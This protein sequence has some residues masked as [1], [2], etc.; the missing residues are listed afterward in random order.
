MF[1]TIPK[2]TLRA[3]QAAPKLIINAKSNL[4]VLACIKLT[5]PEGDPFT[6]RLEA[7]DL[8]QY[9][10]RDFKLPEPGV[11][12][13]A[14]IPYRAFSRF[15]PTGDHVHLH[16]THT[17][18]VF[19]DP[20]GCTGRFELHRKLSD[21]P[22][23]PKVATTGPYRELPVSFFTT[24]RECL[25]F[26]STDETR[27]VLNGI[28]TTPTQAVATDGRRLL[29]KQVSGTPITVIWP[30]RCVKSIVAA[31]PTGANLTLDKSQN[32][33]VLTTDDTTGIF[34]LIDGNYPNY[35]Q[36]IPGEWNETLTF[37]DPEKVEKFLSR[38]QPAD[39]GAFIVTMEWHSPHAVLLHHKK[40]NLIAPAAISGW[41]DA[42]AFNPHFMASA[43]KA[44]GPTLRLI[45]PMSP[46]V[47]VGT[48][49]AAVLM[50]MRIVTEEKAP[51]D[52]PA[53]QT[54]TK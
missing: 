33:A 12:G 3:I 40:G 6:L 17:E 25:P 15:L 38:I 18:A 11:Y 4:P 51:A 27:Y 16:L 24:L 36:I 49:S 2:D 9:L 30:T 29:V 23:P 1:A 14:L 19:T 21:F 7:T 50:P 47:F 32:W 28:H 48:G 20:T 54:A 42:I 5:I 41:F 53:A 37:A 26:V 35:R 46:G 43:I 34:R 22:E 10:R 8:D 39:S 52:K 31:F 13:S 44:V 45:D